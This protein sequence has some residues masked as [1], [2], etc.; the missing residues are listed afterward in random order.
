D[1]PRYSVTSAAVA[2]LNRSAISLTAST[3]SGFAM[4]PPLL[5]RLRSASAGP[6]TT[7]RPGA[8]ARGV[9]AR[10]AHVAASQLPRPPARAARLRDLRSPE[11]DGSSGR[12]EE[13]QRSWVERI[14]RTRPV[15]AARTGS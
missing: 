6:E 12:S 13:D 4:S 10:G 7:K 2:L 3:F 14:Q 8:A 1:N 15:P 11:P 5:F 9:G